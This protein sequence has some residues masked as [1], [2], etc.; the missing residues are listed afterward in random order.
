MELGSSVASASLAC[1]SAP[2]QDTKGLSCGAD[3]DLPGAAMAAVEAQPAAAPATEEVIQYHI[4]YWR[5]SKLSVGWWIGARFGCKKSV[6][7]YNPSDS[8]TVPR[9]GWLSPRRA[10]RCVDISCTHARTHA[11]SRMYVRMRVRR[12]A[13]P[14]TS[15]RGQG[16]QGGRIELVISI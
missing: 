16:G 13:D 11:Y 2:S 3:T 15:A 8:Q 7:G 4:Y 5:F 10:C 9:R 6:V 1:A 14:C 12:V